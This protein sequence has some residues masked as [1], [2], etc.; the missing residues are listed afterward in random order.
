[1]DAK[2]QY[3]NDAYHMQM[4]QA[5]AQGNQVQPL[6]TAPNIYQ[7]SGVSYQPQQLNSIQQHPA[8]MNQAPGVMLSAPPP[9]SIAKMPV[10]DAKF[11]MDKQTTFV[12]QN[13]PML[14]QS[15]DY[16]VHDQEG[17]MWFKFS[18]IFSFSGKKALIDTYNQPILHMKRPFFSF[19]GKYQAYFQK[20]EE[21]EVFR[22]QPVFWS[23][24]PKVKIFLKGNLTPNPDFI[25][26]GTY[27]DQDFDVFDVRSGSEFLVAK[28]TKQR[29]LE[30]VS[31]FLTN[32]VLNVDTYYLTVNPNADAAFIVCLCALFDERYD[33]SNHGHGHHH[34]SGHRRHHHHHHRRRRGGRRR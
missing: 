2:L 24:M 26:R 10:I 17:R 8:A 32:L 14:G 6:Y 1:M 28:V 4:N 15:Q 20:G 13:V 9:V 18:S 5:N 19:S 22:F 33:M 11:C 31:A 12:M 7:N 16:T 27:A 23:W 25:L 29:P 34:N 30:S 3:Q 21:H